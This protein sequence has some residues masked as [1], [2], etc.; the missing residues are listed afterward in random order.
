MRNKK[1]S[2]HKPIILTNCPI[3]FNYYNFVS[4]QFWNSR[5]LYLIISN[6]IRLYT[7]LYTRALTLAFAARAKEREKKCTCKN[8]IERELFV[9]RSSYQSMIRCWYWVELTE[10]VI[11]PILLNRVS[12]LVF[13]HTY[14]KY[15]YINR[16]TQIQTPGH[17]WQIQKIQYFWFIT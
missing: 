2:S 6:Q 14:H 5:E 9:H 12:R 3:Y 17:D 8:G 10:N 16:N 7:I 4:F 1:N 13:I 11:R 15:R